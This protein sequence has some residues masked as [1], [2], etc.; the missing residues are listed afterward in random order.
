MKIHWFNFRLKGIVL[1]LRGWMYFLAT[2]AKVVSF[3]LPTYS[4]VMEIKK[5]IIPDTTVC[6][7]AVHFPES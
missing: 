6:L 4:V 1:L 7:T 3:L 5:E 2:T